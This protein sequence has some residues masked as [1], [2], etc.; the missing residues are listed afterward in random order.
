MNIAE[1]TT[2]WQEQVLIVIKLKNL[3]ALMNILTN[4]ELNDLQA[5][6]WD[7]ILPYLTEEDELETVLLTLLPQIHA[8]EVL[9]RIYQYCQF[10]A[11]ENFWYVCSG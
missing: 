5:H 8:P 9:E 1:K 6:Y 2:D 4:H 3:G 7:K 10:D 11:S